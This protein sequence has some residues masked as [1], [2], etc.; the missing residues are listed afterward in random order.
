[1]IINIIITT[2]TITIIRVIMFI[3]IFGIAVGSCDI[4]SL[5]RRSSS[6]RLFV[7]PSDRFRWSP[8]APAARPA[9]ARRV[10]VLP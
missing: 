7:R 3:N 2:V 9:V 1:M 8:H 10:V 4:A 5:R 6:T